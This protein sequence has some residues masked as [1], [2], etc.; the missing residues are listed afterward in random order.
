MSAKAGHDDHASPKSEGKLITGSVPPFVVGVIVIGI[1]YWIQ[2]KQPNFTHLDA[3]RRSVPLT[4][5][6][7]PGMSKKITN[8]WCDWSSKDPLPPKFRVDKNAD[9]ST[10]LFWV[11]LADAVCYPSTKLPPNCEVA[12]HKEW[13]YH[14]L[15]LAAE[16]GECEVEVYIDLPKK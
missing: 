3:N 8:D 4:L 1:G 7:S 9:G 12:G 11:R 6:S 14:T 2:W 10:P 5:D 15:Q 13:L 16:E